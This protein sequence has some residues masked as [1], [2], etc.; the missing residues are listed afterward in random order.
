M[1]HLRKAYLVKGIS[2]ANDEIPDTNDAV[3]AQ[4]TRFLF[5]SCERRD[6]SYEIRDCDQAPC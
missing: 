3:R 4:A 2:Q 1:R 5:I 6:T